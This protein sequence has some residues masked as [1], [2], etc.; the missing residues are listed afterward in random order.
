MA[1]SIDS[2]SEVVRAAEEVTEESI[3]P[4]IIEAV[5]AELDDSAKARVLDLYNEG[6]ISE[7]SA[8]LLLGNEN[9]EDAIEMARGAEM[10]FSGD[11]SRFIVEE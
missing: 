2:L 4:S 5:R 7:Q 10:M 8:Q 6:K 3:E 11:S 9:F 1:T